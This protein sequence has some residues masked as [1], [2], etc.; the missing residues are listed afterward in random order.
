MNAPTGSQYQEKKKLKKI[1]EKK[2]KKKKEKFG[3]CKEILKRRIT[4]CR[5][6]QQNGDYRQ[7]ESWTHR[8][9]RKKVEDLIERSPVS[10][11]HQTIIRKDRNIE[12]SKEDRHQKPGW[13]LQGK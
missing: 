10:K 6:N 4:R 11:K 9:G 7:T 13:T 2:K 3:H 8:G 5:T 12:E 1:E